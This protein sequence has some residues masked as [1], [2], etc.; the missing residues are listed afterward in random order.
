MNQ[1]H[2]MNE[3]AENWIGMTML[4]SEACHPSVQMLIQRGTSHTA[5]DLEALAK[6]QELA[7]LSV[8]GIQNPIYQCGSVSM[9]YLVEGDGWR[10][11]L[12]MS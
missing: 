7:G 2:P 6:K 12:M 5:K 1:P 8:C 10:A 4:L 9:M 3:P 11:L